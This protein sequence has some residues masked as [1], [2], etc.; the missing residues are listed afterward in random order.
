MPRDPRH[1]P[2]FEP[3]R[4]GPKNTEE[5]LL[6]GAAM[7][8]R[9]RHAARRECQASRREGRRW[10]GRHL[11]RSPA[12]STP[13][14]IRR[15]I[16]LRYPLGRRRRHQPSPHGR[17]GPQMGCAGRR[18]IVAGGVQGQSGQP[19]CARCLRPLS[20]LR[21]RRSTPMKPRTDDI[22]RSCRCTR[23]RRSG[24]RCGLR[25]PLHPWRGTASSRCMRCRAISTA[26]RRLWRHV[27][28]PRAACGSRSLEALRRAADGIA[29]WQR[30]FRSTNCRAL[31]LELGRRGPAPSSR[32]VTQLGLVDLWDVNIGGSAGRGARMPVPRA[33]TSRTTRRR[34]RAR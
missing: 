6:P 32:Y 21:H 23:K 20:I 28:E 15:T 9:R 2:L 26:H 31:G 11:H 5:P 14:S 25:H 1:D 8:R 34:G 18:R 7:H 4:I 19:L 17:R 16:D 3:I 12:R 33:S 22:A 30:A 13:R 10:L 27:R 29:R 24:P